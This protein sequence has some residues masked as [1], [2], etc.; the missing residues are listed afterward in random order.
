MMRRSRGGYLKSIRI[1]LCRRGLCRCSALV[2]IRAVVG[3]GACRPVMKEDVRM[4]RE[5]VG[6]RRDGEA[7]YGR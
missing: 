3:C 6:G 1:L 7:I 2:E 5:R 4:E